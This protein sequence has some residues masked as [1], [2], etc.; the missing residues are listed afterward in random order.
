MLAL[1]TSPLDRP[2]TGD[3]GGMN[4]YLQA[5]TGALS[6][7][8]VTV[9]I[10]TRVT[11]PGQAN[12]GPIQLAP[13]VKVHRVTAGPPT[14]LA[15]EAIK[16]SVVLEFAQGVAA[17]AP[18]H[19]VHSH[20]WLSGLAGQQVAR[21]WGT[22][23]VQTL[24]TV[25]A[26]KNRN[27]ALG[28]KPEGPERLTAEAKLAQGAARVVAVSPAEAAAIVHDLRVPPERVRVVTPGVDNTVFCPGPAGHLVGLPPAMK[29][30]QGYALMAG[31]IQPI[32]G[33]DLAIR[34]I[35]AMSPQVRPALLISGAPS[36]ANLGYASSLRRLAVE[37]GV[38]DD[39]IFLSAVTTE[40]L[41][42]L[43]RGALVTLMPSHS[44]TYG[45]VALES[46]ACG[47]PVVAY[48]G[49]GLRFSV[50]DQVSGLLVS[51]RDPAQWA[52]AI[53]KVATDPALR[54]AL[55]RGGIDLGRRSAWERAGAELWQV[56]QEVLSTTPVL[57]R[58]DHLTT[59]PPW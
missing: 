28:D 45:L 40:R 21:A 29:R 4:V 55:S 26:L 31:R 56:Y 18:S 35:A 37:L 30:P 6:R 8:G 15:K 12:R 2:G 22:R 36:A 44:E 38:D 57:P 43:M 53:T 49:T 48:D 19:L 9:E 23:H 51:S 47:T 34:A 24:H 54:A 10:Y 13:G 33:Q 58:T 46:A 7:L 11:S 14:P 42:G 59:A 32:K 25:A 20:Y 17:S 1:H 16:P 39:V 5:I 27:L 50:A 3:A 52:E 41:A